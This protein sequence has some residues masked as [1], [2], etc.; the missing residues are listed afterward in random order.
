MDIR[1]KTKKPEGVDETQ[2]NPINALESPNN[3][4]PLLL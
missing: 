2:Y 1:L 4:I 3:H